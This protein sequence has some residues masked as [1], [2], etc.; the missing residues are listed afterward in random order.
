MRRTIQGPFGC[1]HLSENRDGLCNQC[2][3]QLSRHSLCSTSEAYPMTL[4]R[5]KSSRPFNVL[6]PGPQFLLP[7]NSIP[8]VTVAGIGL[9]SKKPYTINSLDKGVVYFRS[10]LPNNKGL[11]VCCHGRLGDASLDQAYVTAWELLARFLAADGYVVASI[12]HLG[13]G[14]DKSRDHFLTHI[15][16]LIGESDEVKNPAAKLKLFGKPLVL[17]GQSEGGAGAGAAAQRITD[18]AISPVATFVNA[19]IGLA[20]SSLKNFG[21][22]ADSVLTLQGTHDGDEPAGA[23]SII[24]YEHAMPFTS[25]HFIWIHGANHINMLNFNTFDPFNTFPKDNSTKIQSQTQHLI[26]QNY[27]VGFI[28]WKLAGQ[29]IYRSAFI[30]DGEFDFMS[31][32]DPLVQGDIQKGLLRVFPRYAQPQ[33]LL[34]A[35]TTQISFI[36]LFQAGI[37]ITAQNPALFQPLK[38]F[39]TDLMFDS[40]LTGGFVVEWNSDDK[41]GSEIIVPCKFDKPKFIEFDATLAH[42]STNPKDG[43]TLPTSLILFEE[44]V[45]FGESAPVMVVIPPPLIMKTSGPTPGTIWTRAVSSTIRIPLSL[46]K[47]T[48]A[49]LVKALILHLGDSASSSGRIAVSAFRMAAS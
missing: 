9:T 7:G 19:V 6:R 46:Y 31:S 43:L 13:D 16:H 37:P 28:R 44:N 12:R 30:G 33:P 8:L 35:T 17:I 41:P 48:S 24:P 23:R 40:Q 21:S 39:G 5:V 3:R 25:K 49:Q 36:K 26:V 47:I 10:P 20:P 15:L 4:A 29:Q 42:S 11:I 34:L 38:N 1:A 45:G 2:L 14:P 22:Y 32:L 27:V 18:F